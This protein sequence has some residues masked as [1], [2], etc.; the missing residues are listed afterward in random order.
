MSDRLFQPATH[1]ISLDGVSVLFGDGETYAGRSVWLMAIED[2]NKEVPASARLS[3][4]HG[5]K[6]RPAFQ[7]PDSVFRFFVSGHCPTDEHARPLS[8]EALTAACATCC[9]NLA[10]TSGSH[11]GTETVT[12]L[13]DKLGWLKGT[14]RHLF[15]T[16]VCGPS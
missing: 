10:A 11:A 8:R 6:L 9:K 15:N 16:A 4:A 1:S 14:L 3:G 7:P 5:K 2:F 12:A 13:A